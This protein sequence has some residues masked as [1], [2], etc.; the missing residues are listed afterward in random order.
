MSSTT[1]L[2]NEF[3]KQLDGFRT[4]I[5]T[6]NCAGNEDNLPGMINDS[7]LPN[8]QKKELIKRFDDIVESGVKH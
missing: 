3:N 5:G 7:G 6:G 1:R 2:T 4:C 8:E